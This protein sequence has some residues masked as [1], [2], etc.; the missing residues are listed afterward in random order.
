MKFIRIDNSIISLENVRRVELNETTSQHTR[1]GQK[2]TI[3]H[4]D[5]NVIYCDDNNEYIECG[6]DA[7]GADKSERLMN[8]IFE[9]LTKEA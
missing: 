9:I 8:K 5:V 6:E 7:A 3:N 2:Y 1:S 4:Y